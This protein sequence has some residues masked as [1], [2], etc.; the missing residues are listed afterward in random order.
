MNKEE[1]KSIKTAFKIPPW[2]PQGSPP[3][4]LARRPAGRAL[5]ERVP[6]LC[7]S[8]CVA[9]EGPAAEESGHE[10]NGRGHSRK[11]QPPPVTS[12]G[13]RTTPGK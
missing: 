3:A 12:G 9:G 8:H 5:P 6:R 11:M 1:T 2:R 7:P 4:K 10:M 13:P